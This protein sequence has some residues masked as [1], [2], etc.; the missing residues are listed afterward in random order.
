ML[1]T[2]I[3]LWDEPRG[4]AGAGYAGPTLD[5][6]VLDGAKTRGAVLIFPGGGYRYTSPREGEPIA[7]RFNAAGFHAFVLHYS[8]EPTRYP[9]SL[10][11]AARALKLLRENAA[12]WRI[13]PGE[14][15]VC[16][17]S[18][19]GHLAA[20]LGA[21]G[22]SGFLRSSPGIGSS[23]ERPDALILCYPVISS[24]EFAHRGSFESLLG[25]SA[26]PELLE[27]LS[28]E[29]RI[30]GRFPPSFLWHTF[31]DGAVPLEN[32]LHLALALREKGVHFEYHVYPGEKHGLSLATRETDDDGRGD[33]P[34]VAS[35][36]GLCV[37][38]LELLWAMR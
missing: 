35:W 29:K 27:E 19:G 23:A 8:V 6:Y 1:H 33:L 15:A 13:A 37:E 4:A 18:A 36:M 9:Q 2:T 26:S 38:W 7:L 30:D 12:E 17:F 10:L 11:D 21:M 3:A 5:T 24:G 28:I 34:H 14:I 25:P 20:C 16:G 32:S 31:D 22:D